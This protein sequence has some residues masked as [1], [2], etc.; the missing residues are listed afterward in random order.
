LSNANHIFLINYLKIL[1]LEI[2]VKKY[3][4]SFCTFLI[5]F[6]YVSGSGEIEHK[7]YDLDSPPKDLV[8]CGPNRESVLLL[9]ELDSLYKSEDKGFTWK[10]LNDI[11]TTTGKDQLEE[12]ENEVN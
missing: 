8:W 3:L 10:K 4:F 5:L 11:L 9:S 12:N 6:L 1:Y 7:Q 2:M